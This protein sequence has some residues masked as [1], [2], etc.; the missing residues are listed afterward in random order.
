MYCSLRIGKA[1]N[2]TANQPQNSVDD[3]F[4][5][6]VCDSCFARR[7]SSFIIEAYLKSTKDSLVISKV[8]GCTI[9]HVCSTRRTTV[10]VTVQ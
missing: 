1:W 2:L 10:V 8:S 9:S 5:H 4:Q 3:R 6:L 7:V